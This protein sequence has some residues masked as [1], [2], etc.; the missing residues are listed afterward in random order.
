MAKFESEVA[1]RF[2]RRVVG[3]ARGWIVAQRVAEEERWQ[4]GGGWRIHA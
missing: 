2:A 4:S 3:T 1:E